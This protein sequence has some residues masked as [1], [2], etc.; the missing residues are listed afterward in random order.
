MTKVVVLV[1]EDEPLIRLDLIDR[2]EDA[3]FEVE[4]ASDAAEAIVIL[5]RNHNIRVVFTD[6]QMPGTMDGVALAHYVR[7]RWPPTIIVVCSANPKPDSMPV[8][9]TWLPKPFGAGSFATALAGI[10]EQLAL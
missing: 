8:R 6:I 4:H 2:I 5:E 1:V 3:G 7:D 10:R 9:A